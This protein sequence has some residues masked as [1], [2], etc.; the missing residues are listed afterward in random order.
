MN[1]YTIQPAVQLA[2]Y[3]RFFWVLE[4]DHAYTH[5]SMADVCP[6]M[7]FHY[8]GRFNELLQNGKKEKS[9]TAGINGQTHT[10]RKFHIDK[11]FGIFGV[12]FYPHTIPLL[13]G[14]PATELSNQTPELTILL[15]SEGN[16]L[17]EQMAEASNTLARVKIIEDFI[18]RKLTQHYKSPL[19]VFACIRSIIQQKGMIKVKQ[20]ASDYA[21]SERQFERQFL[22]YSGFNPKLFS[23]IVRFH[24]AME[25][26]GKEHKTLTEI[27]LEAGF[28]DQSH[29]IHD[30]KEFSG[31]NPKEYFS[32]NSGA[33]A[34]RD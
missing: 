14:I 8:N 31:L 23:R 19:P 5:C 26:Y 18:L 7:L 15:R 4:S 27:A 30:F 13:L 11:G 2:D 6:E 34:W 12:Y 24:A 25:Q 22:R 3:V 16:Q 21:V 20:L 28:Y 29:F 9:F 10:P 17:E 1:Y 33:T 32:G